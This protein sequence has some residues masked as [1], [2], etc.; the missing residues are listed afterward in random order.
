MGFIFVGG[1]GHVQ[2]SM[3]VHWPDEYID[4]QLTS[5]QDEGSSKQLAPIPVRHT[6]QWRE[7]HHLLPSLSIPEW[8]KEE[9]MKD[10]LEEEEEEDGEGG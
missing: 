3:A 5:T 7:L 4:F 1:A 9:A 6:L 10:R 8:I 2:Y